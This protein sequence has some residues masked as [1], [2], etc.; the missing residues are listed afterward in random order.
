MRLKQLTSGSLI[1][2]L[3]TIF[4]RG[5]GYLRDLLM[6]AALGASP[7]SQIFVFAFR[8]FGVVRALA[9]ESAIPTIVIDRYVRQYSGA[10]AVDGRAFLDTEW[11][12]WWLLWALWALILSLANPF[13]MAFLLPSDIYTA[14]SGGF[15]LLFSVIFGI[16]LSTTSVSAVYPSL[17]QAQGRF[18]AHSALASLLNI[19][20]ISVFLIMLLLNID[21]LEL[22]SLQVAVAMAVAGLLQIVISC[23]AVGQ[24]FA[25]VIWP[26]RFPHPTRFHLRLA[27]DTLTKMAPV[28]IFNASSPLAAILATLVLVQYNLNITYFFVAER[29]VQLVPGTVGYAL[30]IVLLPMTARARR[31]KAS[32]FLQTILLI[33]VL[34][35]AGC[36]IAA[37]LHQFSRT[38]INLLY[39]HFNFTAGD[40]LTTSVFLSSI[41]VSVV[42]LLIEPVLTNRLFAHMHMWANI[43]LITGSIAI[44][45]VVWLLREWLGTLLGGSPTSVACAV[46]I[47]II[48]TRVILL[49]ILN[50]AIS[51]QIDTRPFSIQRQ[52]SFILRVFRL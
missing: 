52:W 34:L 39:Q 42:P 22:V 21:N 47:F 14:L 1:V 23:F 29:L 37:L 24:P 46:F 51:Y 49:F 16:S 17:F 2:L 13:L 28:S 11:G 4:N 38:V 20:Y 45:L 5:T 27:L 36:I 12:S 30:G 41:A 3:V 15:I 19:V 7:A 48:A 18:F 26:F 50:V 25:A 33:S 40:A 9:A 10:N 8:V 44:C 32:D 35:V 6:T 31:N 43:L